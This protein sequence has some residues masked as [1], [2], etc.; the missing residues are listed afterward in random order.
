MSFK[1]MT[2]EK[3]LLMLALSML[4]VGCGE[5]EIAIEKPPLVRTMTVSSSVVGDDEIYSGS[6][7]GRYETNLAFQVGGRIINRAVDVGSLVSIGNVLMTL[8]ASDYNQ[9]VNQ[10]EAQI[11]STAAQLDLARSNL[12]R[13]QR[14]YDEDA[15]PAATLDQYRTTYEA[16][17]AAHD[18]AVAAARQSYNALSYTQ[19]IADA[20]GV[21]SS[22]NAE[23]G[24]VVA[25]GQTVMT[26]VQTNELEIEIN[27]PENKLPTVNQP[28]T[29]TFW[30]S[31]SKARAVVREIAPMADAAS[32]TY[33]VRLSLLDPPSEIRLGMTAGA[34]FN[35]SAQSTD[36]VIVPLTAILQTDNRPMVW[37]IDGDIVR[38]KA[39]DVQRFEDNQALVKGLKAGD[40]IVTAGVNKL[41]DGQSVRINPK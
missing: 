11:T 5:Q 22:V 28:A 1:A 26:L 7:K 18:N 32:R 34:A 29:I 20:D 38:A 24:Q 3:F 33:R 37:I 31:S 17:V 27:V 41:H 35:S 39:I 15:I 2:M 25:A 4:M 9:Q 12:E 36:G 23:E 30:A 40:Q 16:A 6:V 21:I 13:Y 8:D 14:L 10:A 19:L